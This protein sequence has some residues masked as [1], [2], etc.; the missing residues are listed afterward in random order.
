MSS[1]LSAISAITPQ[2]QGAQQD[3]KSVFVIISYHKR[4]KNVLQNIFP[5]GIV[6]FKKERI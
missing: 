3:N 6:I 2:E 1:F 4:N 5:R